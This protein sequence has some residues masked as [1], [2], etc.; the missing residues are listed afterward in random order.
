MPLFW[1]VFVTNAAVLV[2][3]AAV[4]VVSP[5]T[6]SFPVAAT[7]AIVLVIGL[8]LMLA[9]NFTAF[10][11]GLVAFGGAARTDARR[12]SVASW[13]PRADRRRGS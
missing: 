2:L 5:A 11:P 8:A 6:I 9:L 10:A 1:R 7:E 13:D 3:A 12:R 4:L